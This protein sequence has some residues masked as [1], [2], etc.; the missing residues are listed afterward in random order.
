MPESK[1]LMKS[2]DDGA[3]FVKEIL[4]DAHTYGINVDRITLETADKRW[5]VF[6][7]MKCTSYDPYKA[8]PR[9]LW[10]EWNH[11][12]YR[13]LWRLACDLKAKQLFI[14]FYADKNTAHGDKVQLTWVTEI[15]N[16]KL[17]MWEGKRFTRETFATWFKEKNKK[18]F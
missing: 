6:E 9:K 7:F 1:P 4:G 18:G 17:S 8:D 16:K 11:Y 14:V 2:D 5:V 15:E 13:M 12:K 10:N 3:N